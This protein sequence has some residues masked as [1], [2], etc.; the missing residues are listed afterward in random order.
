MEYQSRPLDRTVSDRQ[1]NP[2][3]IIVLR[4]FMKLK[5]R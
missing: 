2:Y 4:G 5:E 1:N 3:T